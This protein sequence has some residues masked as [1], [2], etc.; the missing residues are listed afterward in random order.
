MG[1]GFGSWAMSRGPGRWQRLILAELATRPRFWLLELL[2]VG[3]PRSHHNGLT[4]AAAR[5]SA[6]GKLDLWQCRDARRECQPGRLLCVRPGL[7]PGVEGQ[8]PPFDHGRRTST[9]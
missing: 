7:A 1:R 4:R 5:L 2:P 3:Y 6:L 9:T 8:R